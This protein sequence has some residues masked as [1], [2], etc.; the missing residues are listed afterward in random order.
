MYIDTPLQG[1]QGDPRAAPGAFPKRQPWFF[2]IS[3]LATAFRSTGVCLTGPTT[4][5]SL[6]SV[7]RGTGKDVSGLLREDG[8]S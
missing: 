1:E 6:A 7:E 3:T 4:Q 2:C 8:C 5:L